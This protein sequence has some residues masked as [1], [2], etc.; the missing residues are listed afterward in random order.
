VGEKQELPIPELALG[1]DNA[2]ELVRVWAAHGAQ[3][4]SLATGLWKDPAAW[5]IMLVDLA[6]HVAKAYQSAGGCNLR[7][8]RLNGSRGW[9]YRPV[10]IGA[11][12]LMAA[13]AILGLAGYGVY[14]LFKGLV[15]GH[16]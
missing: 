8:G 16:R 2:R 12:P 5:G 6:R 14:R 9:W 7:C 1:D 15:S 10:S 13:G 4:V 11:A 3:H